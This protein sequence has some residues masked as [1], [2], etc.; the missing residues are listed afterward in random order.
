MNLRHLKLITPYV[1]LVVML[2]LC[3][4]GIA[5]SFLYER[6]AKMEIQSYKH[7]LIDVQYAELYRRYGFDGNPLMSE[8]F[9]EKDSLQ[10]LKGFNH[11]LNKYFNYYEVFNVQNVEYVEGY[12]K[13]SPKFV[14]GYDIGE[15]GFINQRIPKGDSFY[16]LT[17][18]EAVQIGLRAMQDFDLA[19]K[20][21]TGRC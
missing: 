19:G 9:K 6:Y 11:D 8:L 20:V 18:L 12:Y 17:P 14:E 1:I 21:E 16:Y 2:S 13:G 10:R 4:V 7:N 3:T 5:S 15:G